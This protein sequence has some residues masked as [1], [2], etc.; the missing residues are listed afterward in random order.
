MLDG[1]LDVPLLPVTLD[2]LVQRVAL[3]D[4]LEQPALRRQRH[5]CEGL[6][7]NVLGLNGLICMQE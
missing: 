7:R 1:E 2:E 3:G 4:P 6:D 5:H